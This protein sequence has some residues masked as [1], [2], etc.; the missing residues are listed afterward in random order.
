MVSVQRLGAILHKPC[1]V[2]TAGMS[3]SPELLAVCA[4]W[5]LSKAGANQYSFLERGGTQ[6]E[7]GAVLGGGN[8]NV[9]KPVSASKALTDQ[10]R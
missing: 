5:G 8:V 7:S 10:H 4:T 3:G 9:Q 2:R 1:P 6:N